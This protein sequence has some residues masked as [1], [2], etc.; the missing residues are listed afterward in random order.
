MFSVQQADFV[1]RPCA[2]RS[3]C[4]PTCTAIYNFS[5]DLRFQ[6]CLS[7]VLILF[8]FPVHR[9]SLYSTSSFLQCLPS[10]W[11]SSLS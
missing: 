6:I 2:M 3:K 8:L 1:R 4:R 10:G 7:V 9:R 11:R 5:D